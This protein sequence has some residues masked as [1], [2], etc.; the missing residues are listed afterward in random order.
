[1]YDPIE[2]LLNAEERKNISLSS[3]LRYF[4]V[5][6]PEDFDYSAASQAV[7]CQQ[8]VE[9]SQLVSQLVPAE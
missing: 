4:Q 1:V 9:Q 7:V 8:L 5:V 2:V 6:P 3:V